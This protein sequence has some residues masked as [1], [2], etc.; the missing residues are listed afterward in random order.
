MYL[1]AAIPGPPINIT[2]LP[3]VREAVISWDN[4]GANATMYTLLYKQKQMNTSSWSQVRKSIWHRYNSVKSNV[5]I[6]LQIVIRNI[7]IVNSAVIS[8]KYMF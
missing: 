2:V 7:L 3:G 4:N 1:A 8:L 6:T 5:I